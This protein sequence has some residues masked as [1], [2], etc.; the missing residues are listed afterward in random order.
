[1]AGQW[2][3]RVGDE[4]VGN[5]LE[6]YDM[7]AAAYLLTRDIE[8]VEVVREAFSKWA[9]FRFENSDGRASKALKE[10][11][12]GQATANVQQFV[13]AYKRVRRAVFETA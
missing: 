7:N 5:S 6:I 10:F 12:S 9:T 11:T 2:L 3:E 1:M 4:Q 8:L 13:S